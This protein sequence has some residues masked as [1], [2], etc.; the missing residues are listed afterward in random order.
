VDYK[1]ASP[2]YDENGAVAVGSYSLSIPT[3]AIQCLYKTDKVPEAAELSTTYDD[4]S[5][6]YTVTKS[7]TNKDGWINVSVT[8]L[9][10][11]SP[12]ISAKFGT[13]SSGST[14]FSALST[15]APAASSSSVA[16]TT[17][18]VVRTSISG[19]RAVVSV[20]LTAKGTVS[21]YR[22]VGSKLTLIK[23]FTAK[24]GVNKVTTTFRKGYSF[25]VKDARG[26][27]IAN[28]G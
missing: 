9:H 8:G 27:T 14:G 2:H 13:L 15:S 4:G 23:R 17:A 21:V 5:S 28:A 22:K 24:K 18:N 7:L 12:T 1:V 3:A 20:T 25:I 10:F 26:K 16:A 19:S 6:T 11:S